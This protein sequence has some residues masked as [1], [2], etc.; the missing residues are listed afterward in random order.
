VERLHAVADGLD[1]PAHLAVPALVEDELEAGA[2]ETPSPGRRGASV[3]EVHA[4]REL[5]QR[6]VGRLLPGLDL[7]DLLD[8][9]ARV[10]EPVRERAVVREQE[11]A[12]R[13]DVEAADRDDARLVA[14]EVDHRRPALR[15]ARGRDH[16]R[17]LV[18]E[19]VGEPLLRDGPPVDLDHVARCDEGV[20]LPGLAV[21]RHPSG[22]DQLVGGAT[23]GHARAR[24]IGIESHLVI[25]TRGSW[26]GRV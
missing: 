23:G 5:A 1:H 8:P 16:A 25:L 3:L 24:Q 17:R 7:V 15:V 19:H 26:R 18:Q 2:G 9:V 4:L 14:D 12:G 21:D 13:V 11:R 22:L 10:R 6:P 20:Q